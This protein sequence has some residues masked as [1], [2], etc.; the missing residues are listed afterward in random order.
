MRGAVDC[1]GEEAAGDDGCD[2]EC[3]RCLRGELSRAF[4]HSFLWVVNCG[5]RS[6]RFLVFGSSAVRGSVRRLPLP[7]PLSGLTRI[8][9]TRIND[10]LRIRRMRTKTKI[11]KSSRMLMIR[12]KGMRVD[13][14]LSSGEMLRLPSG[15]DGSNYMSGKQSM[16]YL[17]GN[18]K[19][20]DQLR[21]QSLLQCKKGVLMNIND[22]D[23][24][25]ASRKGS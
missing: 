6:C 4:I 12:S 2:W 16:Q 20:Y 9:R 10:S 24:L 18:C 19:W 13:S 17:Q 8:K 1:R 23:F 5:Q 22:G 25:A 7:L 14:S 11:T 15:C 21:F 3:G